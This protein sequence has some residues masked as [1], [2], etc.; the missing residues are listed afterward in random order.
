MNRNYFVCSIGAPNEK[1]SDENLRRC[2]DNKCFVLSEGSAQKGAINDIKPDDLLLLK[3]DKHFVA[4]GK[5]ISNRKNE[6]I[7]NGYGWSLKIDVN[8]W[9]VGNKASISGI[10]NAQDGGSNY[11]TVR[12]IERAFALQKI[13]EIGLML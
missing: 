7:S 12:K 5:A 8:C 10:K 1:Y 13:E 6:D 3:Y 2:I 4:Y 11:A 9:I